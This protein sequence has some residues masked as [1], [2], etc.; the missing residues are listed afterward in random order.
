MPPERKRDLRHY[1]TA[2]DAREALPDLS[3]WMTDDDMKLL[4]IWKGTRFESGQHYFDL[5]NPSRGPFVAG[6]DEPPPKDLTYVARNEV[7]ENVWMKLMTW[8]Q[9][10]DESQ[11]QA[12]QGLSD[13]LGVGLEQSAAGDARPL[14]R[15]NDE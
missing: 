9:P 12:I 13:Q 2:Y 15:S 5:D 6:G 7:P 11:A 14:P 3:A 1:L 8:G 10:I 4:P